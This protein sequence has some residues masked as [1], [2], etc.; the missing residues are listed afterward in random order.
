MGDGFNDYSIPGAVGASADRSLS[1]GRAIMGVRTILWK[2]INSC[3]AAMGY[4]LINVPPVGVGLTMNDSLERLR[5]AGLEIQTIIDIGASD[6]RWTRN[7]MRFFP[8]ASALLVEPLEERRD[9]LAEFKR[10][11]PRVDYA[12]AA[13]AAQE[14]EGALHVASDL[15]GSGLCET[16]SENTRSVPLTTVDKLIRERNLKPPFLMKLDTHGFEVPILEG[17]RQTL[18]ATSILIVEVYN[19][20]LTPTSLRFHEMC[21]HLEAFGFRCFDLV[22][23]SLRP[24]DGAFW[25]MDLVFIS[26]DSS[27][28]SSSSYH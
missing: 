25:Q 16:P 14:G 15:V 24:K 3:L 10:Q 18:R 21:A 7:A 5:R 23:P 9:A 27:I 26:K 28:F 6:G 2:T 12:I 22:D 19:F 13:A 1:M 4:E 20:Q 8:A 17:A 11:F